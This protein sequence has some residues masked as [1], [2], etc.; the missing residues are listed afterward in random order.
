MLLGPRFHHLF[1]IP[2]DK[3][4]SLRQV[5]ATAFDGKRSLSK[6]V[7]L[8]FVFC[9]ATTMASPAQTLSTVVSFNGASG[10]NPQSPLIQATDG[11]FY[12][13]T[14]QGGATNNGTIFKITPTGTLTTLYSFGGADGS[15]ASWRAS[16]RPPSR[17][18]GGV[19]CGFC[20]GTASRSHGPDRA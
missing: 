3:Y 19:R 9:A 14:L 16:R 18:S 11:N 13:T 2:V 12:G 20:R 5:P 7:C 15:G 1:R 10:A 4:I 17:T 6:M 8:V